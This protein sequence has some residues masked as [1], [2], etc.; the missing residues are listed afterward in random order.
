MLHVGQRMAEASRP[1]DAELHETRAHHVDDGEQPG[2]KGRRSDQAD[3]N[4][5]WHEQATLESPERVAADHFVRDS[6]QQQ[7]QREQDGDR[8]H[9]SPGSGKPAAEVDRGRGLQ[10]VDHLREGPPG[11]GLDRVVHGPADRTHDRVD[12]VQEAQQQCTEP[13]TP[14]PKLTSAEA[15]PAT[16]APSTPPRAIDHPL[17]SAL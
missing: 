5:Q 10:G 13:P 7:W 12:G 6:H 4:E 15:A 14:N 8:G 1:T 2:Q 9:R 3:P 17:C 11:D 16:M